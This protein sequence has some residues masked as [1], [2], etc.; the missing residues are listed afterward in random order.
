M[1][2]VPRDTSATSTVPVAGNATDGLDR[3][4]LHVGDAVFPEALLSHLRRIAAVDHCMVFAFTNDRNAQCLIDVG[5]IAN[6]NDLG[7]AY[8]GHFHANDP[9][10]EMMFGRD[11]GSD[12][13]RMPFVPR[14]MY[15]RNYRK[16]FFDDAGIV[17]K[18]AAALWHDGVCIYTN[19]Y[20]VTASG[21]YSEQ[22]VAALH[23]ASPVLAAT[24]ARHCQLSLMAKA[25]DPQDAAGLLRQAFSTAPLSS[26]TARER[27]VCANILLGF[28]SE[29]I[30]SELDISL[31]SVLTYRRRAYQ[32]LGITSQNELFS[33]VMMQLATR[34]ERVPFAARTPLRSLN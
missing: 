8:A 2:V 23:R 11:G 15:R 25:P 6:G 20:R 28:S 3:A 32:R 22:Q 13:I 33:I 29:A 7:D 10:K 18:Y 19:F 27:D 21:R 4:I 30:A 24:I 16:L 14:G 34:G 9:N 31:N 17:D 1:A 12:P 5:N 26:L